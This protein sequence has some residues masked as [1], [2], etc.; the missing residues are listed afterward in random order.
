VADVEGTDQQQRASR[1]VEQKQQLVA[2]L[3]GVQVSA[4][5][6]A[7][8]GEHSQ[9]DGAERQRE[10]RDAARRGH[11]V[12][13]HVEHTV[14]RQLVPLEDQQVGGQPEREDVGSQRPAQEEPRARAVVLRSDGRFSRVRVCHGDEGRRGRRERRRELVQC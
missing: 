4:S 2:A 5:A 7:L 1:R 10:E 12:A 8:E 11:L 6:P 3:V 9:L 14:Q 13:P